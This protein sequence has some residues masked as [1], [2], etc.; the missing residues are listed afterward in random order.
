MPLDSIIIHSH[1]CPRF[2]LGRQLTSI[3]LGTVS[4]F[5]FDCGDFHFADDPY[6][7]IAHLKNNANPGQP[8]DGAVSLNT[9]EFLHIRYDGTRIQ[10]IELVTSMSLSRQ[11]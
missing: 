1:H 3:S 9:L 11:R 5:V 6:T 8:L 2:M 10:G 4:S 7:G